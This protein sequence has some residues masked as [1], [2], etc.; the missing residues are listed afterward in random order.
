MITID[1]I[2]TKTDF[3]CHGLTMT[4]PLLTTRTYC[5]RTSSQQDQNDVIEMF[6]YLCISERRRDEMVKPKTGIRTVEN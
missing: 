3:H 2:I 6:R 4:D 5:L 1:I